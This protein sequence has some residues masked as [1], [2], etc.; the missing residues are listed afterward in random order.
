MEHNMKIHYN[1]KSG[2]V[3]ERYPK[4]LK[5]DDDCLELEITDAEYADTLQ[6][7]YG[8][9]WAIKND[10]LTKIDDEDIINTDEYRKY[11]INA[12]I[13]QYQSYLDTT[14][15]VITKLNEL[16]LEDDESY[17]TEKANYEDTLSKRKTAREKINI[18][19][20]ELGN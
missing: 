17:E 11:S 4:D 18:L 7:E 6:C 12:E 2:I 9:V 8:K 19:K 3:C 10:I 16:R 1:K 20:K 13:S 5:I 14:D 15:Y